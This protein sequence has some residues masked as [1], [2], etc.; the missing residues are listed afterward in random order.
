MGVLLQPS[1]SKTP[2][3]TKEILAAR[4]LFQSNFCSV[5]KLTVLS[6]WASIIF[7]SISVLVNNGGY[8]SFIG[9]EGHMLRR[10]TT[11]AFGSQSDG[12]KYQC[13]WSFLFL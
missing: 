11:M 4:S 5:V 6:F 12:L 2:L 9:R 7:L 13:I 1:F 10:G 3:F 8:A